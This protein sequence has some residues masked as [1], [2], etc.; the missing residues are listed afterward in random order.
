MSVLS[1]ALTFAALSLVL[2]LLLA[3]SDGA[4]ARSLS[5]LTR[6]A[7]KQCGDGWMVPRAEFKQFADKR[8]TK[9]YCYRTGRMRRGTW[10]DAALECRRSESELVWVT[11]AEEA[12]WLV[13]VLHSYAIDPGQPDW[14]YPQ[15]GWMVNAHR[16]LYSERY[17]EGAR[18]RG[19]LFVRR[20]PNASEELP[21]S[22]DEGVFKLTGSFQNTCENTALV[23]SYASTTADGNKQSQQKEPSY[24]SPGDCF[25]VFTN[26][27]NSV[28]CKDDFNEEFGYVCKK[29]FNDP[30]AAVSPCFERCPAGWPQH[31]LN[32]TTHCYFAGAFTGTAITWYEALNQCRLLGMELWAPVAASETKYLNSL[33]SGG[34]FPKEYSH[35]WVNAHSQLYAGSNA[36][37]AA[38]PESMS[39]LYWNSGQPMGAETV[40]G[41]QVSREVV[42]GGDQCGAA[43]L[44]FMQNQNMVANVTSCTCPQAFGYLC[45]ASVCSP[46]ERAR[47][48]QHQQRLEQRDSNPLVVLLLILLIVFVVLTVLLVLALVILLVICIC[49]RRKRASEAAGPEAANEEVEDNGGIPESIPLQSQQPESEY[50]NGPNSTRST[51]DSRAGAA[52]PPVRVLDPNSTQPNGTMDSNKDGPPSQ[53]PPVQVNAQVLRDTPSSPSGTLA[54]SAS[55]EPPPAIAESDEE[56]D[57]H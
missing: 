21:D 41:F 5:S 1:T 22:E 29:A 30:V 18:W 15:K 55:R 57:K 44:F 34:Y 40:D 16:Y 9:R 53:P 12:A 43:Y 52:P 19:G 33:L 11:D 28:P 7:E 23:G 2:S 8:S 38:P 25:S 54:S 27:L 56:D 39:G 45:R 26:K 37:G 14:F 49:C 46:A 6:S 48:T 51:L 36:S 24:K 17:G 35:W 47:K 4:A 20:P 3:R 31:E 10:V 42:K 32:G 13:N 50:P